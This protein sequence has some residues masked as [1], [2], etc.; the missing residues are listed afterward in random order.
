MFV[1][2]ISGIKKIISN[3]GVS[4]IIKT[5]FQSFGLLEVLIK[6]LKKNFE[7]YIFL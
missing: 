1:L 7:E 2:Y 3:F 5:K 4:C 6:S